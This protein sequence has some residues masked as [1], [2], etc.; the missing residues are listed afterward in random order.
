MSERRKK[1]VDLVIRSV[2]GA[3]VAA[4]VT[5]LGST[6][7]Y[8]YMRIPTIGE[9]VPYYPQ[10]ERWE[11]SANVNILNANGRTSCQPS[12]NGTVEFLGV[13]DGN[14]LVKYR[15]NSES[16]TKL[17][18]SNFDSDRYRI[19]WCPT[20]TSFY[21]NSAYSFLSA[22]RR[23]RDREEIIKKEAAHVKELEEQSKIINERW[24]ARRKAEEK[25]LAD[26]L[27]PPVK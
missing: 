27:P 7:Y 26:H 17:P 25:F 13:F 16:S 22:R 15:R 23:L 21:M 24:E 14:F 6:Y 8:D 19:K 10:W 2:I 3:I 12:R 18:E 4:G 11:R 1:V 5:V 20:G 9:T